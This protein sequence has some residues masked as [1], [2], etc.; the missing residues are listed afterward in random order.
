MKPVKILYMCDPER[1]ADC[2]KGGCVHNPA[3]EYGQ[4]SLTFEPEWA[5]RDKNG[6]PMIDLENTLYLLKQDILWEVPPA[7][8]YKYT[9]HIE[10][11][12][13]LARFAL[14]LGI[15]EAVVLAV[16]VLG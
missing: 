2:T 6:E 8:P 4:C 3:S 5:K 16:L 7:V 12:V 15:V 11:S 14:G 10:L 13:V 9:A 1:A